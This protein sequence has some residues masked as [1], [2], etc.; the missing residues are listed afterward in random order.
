MADE[1]FISEVSSNDG[2]SSSPPPQTENA[3]AANRSTNQWQDL[4]NELM[5]LKKAFTDYTRQNLPEI[6]QVRQQLRDTAAERD[7]VAGELKTLRRHNAIKTLASQYGFTDAEYLDF[8]LQK[9]N[10]EPDNN[11]LA[12]AFMQQFRQT[13]P[14]YFALPVKPGSGSRPGSAPA[15]GK[16]SAGS[17]LDMLEDMLSS[18]PELI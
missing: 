14:R 4:Q 15:A 10:V 18:A 6:D 7:N 2:T 3:A 13:N 1:I 8:V 11:D 16:N 9:N 17:A 12:N 5:A